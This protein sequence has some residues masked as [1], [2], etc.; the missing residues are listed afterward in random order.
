MFSAIFT[1]EHNFC[2]FLLASLHN[3][4]FQIIGL[5]VKEIIASREADSFL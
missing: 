5:L 2:D 4:T 3:K 1:K